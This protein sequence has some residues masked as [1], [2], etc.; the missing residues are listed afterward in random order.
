[1]ANWPFMTLGVSFNSFAG[2]RG[3]CHKI[4]QHVKVA[5]RVKASQRELI[6]SGLGSWH[7]LGHFEAALKAPGKLQMHLVE[8]GWCVTSCKSPPSPSGEEHFG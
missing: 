7:C 8:Q 5:F 2:D 6:T 4:P 1:M 3:L